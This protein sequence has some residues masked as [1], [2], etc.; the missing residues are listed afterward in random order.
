M[1]FNN[2]DMVLVTS[3]EQMRS[4][5]VKGAHRAY[6]DVETTSRDAN[7]KS[8]SVWRDCWVCGVAITFDD[9]PFAYYIPCDHNPTLF[10]RFNLPVAAVAQWLA[11]V[12]PTVTEWHNAN[13]KY[14]MH[15]IRQTFGVEFSGKV[16]CTTTRA[17]VFNSEFFAYDLDL[18]CKYFID[19]DLKHYGDLIAPYVGNAAGEN[20][21]YGM[22]P[23]DIMVHYA[24]ADVLAVRMLTVFFDRNIDTSLARVES[25]ESGG[26]RVLYEIEK[27]GLLVNPTDLQIQTLT[28][29]YELMRELS[30][31]QE[32]AQY[33]GFNPASPKCMQELFVNR[34]GLPVLKWTNE[35]DDSP[36]AVHN[37][38]FGKGVLEEYLVL[39]GVPTKLIRAV[40]DLKKKDKFYSA[41]L[42]PYLELH[43]NGLL[44]SD[45][46]QLVRTG[47]MSCRRPNSQQLHELAKMLIIPGEEYS[48]LSVDQ[49]Q[50]E[51]RFI[52]HYIADRRVVQAFCDNPDEDF[53]TWV[54]DLVQIAR[55]PAKT[56]N[57]LMA[58]GGGKGMLVKA[59]MKLEELMGRLK[60]QIDEAMSQGVLNQKQ[61]EAE[62]SVKAHAIALNCYNDYHRAMPT[63]KPTAR[64]AEISCRANGY[65]RNMYGRR[66]HLGRE[67]A[68]KAFNTVCQGSAADTTKETLINVWPL[69]QSAGVRI[70]AVVHDEILYRGPDKVINDPEFIREVVRITE[71]PEPET[72]LTV[73]IRCG[74]GTSANNWKEAGKESK[75]WPLSDSPWL[76]LYTGNKK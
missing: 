21:D 70:A 67:H 36:G 13:I 8:I 32:L 74:Y 69:C 75:K 9:H 62:F 40:M 10:S 51:Y 65:V 35:D 2:S 63:L 11:E 16:V 59:L 17:K 34:L 48:F 23:P 61:A 12:L 28:T 52:A 41:F 15:A 30:A 53:H 64:D 47:R 55:K 54:A 73:P 50:I 27:E 29:A 39:P 38:S 46:N 31:V 72:A 58:F 25:L 7:K 5:P 68:H 44:H 1:L 3:V 56:I 66:R 57:F 6:L 60:Q 24:C 14:D 37:P 18:I 45:Y 71:T 33:P 43:V 26:T 42:K 76:K 49:S 19:V 20:K 22:I 4:I